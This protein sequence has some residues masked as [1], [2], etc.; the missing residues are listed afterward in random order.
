M[1]NIKNCGRKTQNGMWDRMCQ[2]QRCR[3][4]KSAENRE[5]EKAEPLP[6]PVVVYSPRGI[7]RSIDNVPKRPIYCS[8]VSVDPA[9]VKILENDETYL[10][11]FD[12]F[13]ESY[14]SEELERSILSQRPSPPPPINSIGS[15]DPTMGISSFP[16]YRTDDALVEFWTQ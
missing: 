14:R 3:R 5:H 16:V 6:H 9:P 13:N 4:S 8:T 7:K 10:H 2:I 11:Y 15:L 1:L 12:S